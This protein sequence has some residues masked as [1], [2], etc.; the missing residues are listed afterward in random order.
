MQYHLN[1]KIRDAPMKIQRLKAK[2]LVN[3]FKNK[4]IDCSMLIM[5]NFRLRAKRWSA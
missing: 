1:D 3:L 4:R 2:Y 5:R